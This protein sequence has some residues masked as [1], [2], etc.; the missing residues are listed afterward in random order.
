M[1]KEVFI[2]TQEQLD[3]YTN[4]CIKSTRYSIVKDSSL[5]NKLNPLPPPVKVLTE[6]SQLQPPV[7]S[8]EEFLKEKGFE[9]K[10]AIVEG[11]I[12]IWELSFN[13]LQKLLTE[14]LQRQGQKPGSGFKL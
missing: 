1:E 11:E 14:Y 8:A 13:S 6:A 2:L 5:W 9:D 4:F 7:I 12:N 3:A 10:P